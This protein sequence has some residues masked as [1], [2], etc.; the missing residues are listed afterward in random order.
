MRLLALISLEAGRD[1]EAESLLQKRDLPRARISSR[2]LSTSASCARSRIDTAKRSSAS[3]VRSRSIP[4]NAQTHYLRGS[5]LAPAAFTHEA[6]DAY[7]KCLELRPGHIGALIGLGHVLKAVGRYDDAVAAYDACIRQRPDLG[8]TYWS[9]AN[10][11]TYRFDDATVAEMERRV[12]SG[13]TDRA[14]R[15]EFPLRARQGL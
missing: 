4:D 2:R 10:L 14:I 13:G 15:S 11:K 1:G 12:R 6:I 3:T 9:L 7:R 5:T 8:E